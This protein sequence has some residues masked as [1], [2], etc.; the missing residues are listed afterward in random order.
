[1]FKSLNYTKNGYFT[2]ANG[3]YVITTVTSIVRIDLIRAD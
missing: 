2:T 1:M 3:A